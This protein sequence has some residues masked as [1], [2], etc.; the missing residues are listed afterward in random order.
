MPTNQDTGQ[1]EY[2][3]SSLDELG[4]ILIEADKIEYV[5]R[6]LNSLIKGVIKLKI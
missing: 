6:S 2:Y 3:L 4:E 5:K 1:F